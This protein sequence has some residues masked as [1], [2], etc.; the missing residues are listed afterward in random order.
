MIRPGE[1][2]RSW[3]S[4]SWFLAQDGLRFTYPSLSVGRRPKVSSKS[5]GVIVRLPARA[6]ITSTEVSSEGHAGL[7]A[8][9]SSG[10]LA[11]FS[12]GRFTAGLYL[13]P[14]LSSSA[15][16]GFSMHLV[17]Q[18]SNPPNEST[19]TTLEAFPVGVQRR[20]AT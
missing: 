14:C 7:E 18:L 19:I 4:V 12:L 16:S 10:A 9:R 17:G 8:G 1:F 20:S 6:L 13:R 3:S 2:S 15:D 5:A 11:R